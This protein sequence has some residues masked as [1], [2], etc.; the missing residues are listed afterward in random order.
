MIYYANIYS[1]L[2][3][4][5]FYHSRCAIP[6]THPITGLQCSSTIMSP[7]PPVRGNCSFKESSHILQHFDCCL[8]ACQ[9]VALVFAVFLVST[10]YFCV[11]WFYYYFLQEWIGTRIPT[12]ASIQHQCSTKCICEVLFRPPYLS[13]G[14][15]SFLSPRTFDKGTIPKIRG[16]VSTSR[17]KDISRYHSWQCSTMGKSWQTF[18]HK[19]KSCYSFIKKNFEKSVKLIQQLI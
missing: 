9:L 10:Y 14:Q 11:K 4:S 6:T 1:R 2:S 19:K 17:W 15:W 18:C 7:G 13:W 3:F 16:H 8:P 5:P 12:F